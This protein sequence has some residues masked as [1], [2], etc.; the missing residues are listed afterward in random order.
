MVE[1]TPQQMQTIERLLEAGFRPLSVPLYENALCL[2]RGECAA[3]LAPVPGGGLKLLA[4]ASYLVEGNLGV[5][6]KRAGGEVFIWKK[7]E[8]TATP[9]R[10]QELEKFRADLSEILNLPGTQ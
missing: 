8:V 5:R 9:E 7:K 6:W 1:F 10:L 3:V 4:P 2:R